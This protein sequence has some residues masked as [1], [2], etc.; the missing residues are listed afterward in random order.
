MTEI[1]Q[2]NPDDSSS[3]PL[4]QTETVSSGPLYKQMQGLIILLLIGL[5]VV[6]AY[7]YY[8][9]QTNSQAYGNQ[10]YQA[11]LDENYEQ[12]VTDY[13][14]AIELKPDQSVLYLLRGNAYREL[15]QDE[16][17]F[18]DYIKS[19]AL[20]PDIPASA[21]PRWSRKPTYAV[22]IYG[23]MIRMEPDMAVLHYLLGDALQRVEQSE[24]AIV[25][26]TKAIAL[27]SDFR[28]AYRERGQILAESGNFEQAIQNYEQ[29]LKLG[30]ANDSDRSQIEQT[31]EQLKTELNK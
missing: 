1:E 9:Y 14:K 24:E 7:V 10:G 3:V 15:G 16:Q 28:W 8:Q 11:Y 19:I 23:R 31:V 22:V 18:A 20:N 17:A 26:F 30:S 2:P 5:A 13:T 6:G 27:E 4:P 12:A 21:Q 25:A 29:Y